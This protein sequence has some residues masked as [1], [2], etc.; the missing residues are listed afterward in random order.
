V[1]FFLLAAVVLVDALLLFN[2]PA[3]VVEAGREAPDRLS[4]GDRNILPVR[5]TNRYPFR[6]S[7]RLIDE[8]PLQFQAR[9]FLLAAE[10][11]PGESLRMEYALRPTLRGA[12]RFGH[13]NVYARSAI[14]LL[15]RRFR[16]DQG[17]EVAVYPAFLQ[18]R[19][20]ELLAISNRL[21][22]AGVK[23]VRRIAN[24][25][26]FEQIRDYVLGDDYRD[27]NWKATARRAHLMVNQY[28]DEKSQQVFCVV[29]MGRTMRS[30]FGGMSLLDYAINA[31]LVLSNIAMHKQDKAGLVTFSN[32]MGTVLPAAR[33]PK[34]MRAILE[35]LY[36]Q[37]TDFKE[38]DHE[39]LYANL[40]RKIRQR[41][42]VLLFTN[43]EG[44]VS[45]QRQ[46]PFLQALAK[47]HLVV[48]IFFENTELRALVD[49]EA[50]DLETAYIQTIAE[51]YAYEKRLIVKEFARHGIM[52]VLTQPQNLTV[53]TLNKYLEIKSMGKF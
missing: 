16:F 18:M 39:L 13:L 4:N 25:K 35:S 51:K 46:M 38:S 24:N 40:K 9:D 14:G 44:L 2:R 6:M 37:E 49:A 53:D 22:E 33:G 30:P 52:S 50:L 1:L 21:V 8:L 26:E 19:K 23:K 12:Y 11:G 45:A 27:I 43:F 36:K 42:L 41:S 29:D 15:E 5:L 28:Q 17:K 34:Q 32:K 10:L 31:S 20:Y 7:F 47:S 3:D 48:V